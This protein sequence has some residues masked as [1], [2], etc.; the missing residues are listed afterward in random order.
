[1]FDEG[2]PSEVTN[3]RGEYWFLDLPAGEYTV[4]GF[5]GTYPD[6]ATDSDSFTFE[7]AG[8]MKVEVPISAGEAPRR[9]PC[10]SR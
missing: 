9:E 4:A 2:E 3:E 6:G 7:K 1:M 8:T 5:V 10:G